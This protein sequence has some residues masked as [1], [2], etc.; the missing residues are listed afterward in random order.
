MLSFAIFRHAIPY[1]L[2]LMLKC[3]ILAC[4]NDFSGFSGNVLLYPGAPIIDLKELPADEDGLR[5]MAVAKEPVPYDVTISLRIHVTQVPIPNENFK[6]VEKAISPDVLS[7][8]EYSYD[9]RC[10]IKKGHQ[11]YAGKFKPYIINYTTDSP[12]SLFQIKYITKRATL[13]IL[14]WPDEGDNPYN[15]GNAKLTLNS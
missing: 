4:D 1:L 6:T 8:F 10:N 2:V 7:P 15:V 5:Y 12:T 13:E 14:A 9:Q 3:S 11:V